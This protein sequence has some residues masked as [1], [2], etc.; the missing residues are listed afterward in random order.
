MASLLAPQTPAAE[1]PVYFNVD[2]TVGAAPAENRREDVL[3]VQFYCS[4][5]SKGTSTLTAEERASF[6]AVKVTGVVDA[7]TIAAIRAAQMK[8]KKQQPGTVVDGRVSPAKGGYNYGGGFW[9]IASLN[10]VVHKDNMNTW[11]RIDKIAGCPAEIQQM[12]KRTLVGN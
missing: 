1:M 2:A 8:M 4:L 9:T 7:E 5:I 11:P 10:S 3:L 6:D 12:V